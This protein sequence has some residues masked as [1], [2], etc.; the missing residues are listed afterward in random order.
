[1]RKATWGALSL[2]AWALSF[3]S[4]IREMPLLHQVLGVLLLVGYLL[5]SIDPPVPTARQRTLMIAGVVCGIASVVVVLG[6]APAP[7]LVLARLLAVAVAALP[8]W[9][10]AGPARAGFLAAGVLAIVTIVPALEKAGGAATSL[11]AYVAALSCF[12]VALLLE[13]PAL[14]AAD[15]Q[16]KPPRVVVARD[17]VLLSPE[18]KAKRLAALEKRYQAGEIPEHKYWDKRQEI[19]SR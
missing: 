8:L 15:G 16:R 6:G 3:G 13:R 7:L 9:L 18:E 10:A 2:G 5:L 4:P 11:H 12:A 19:E 17:V 14:L 1:M